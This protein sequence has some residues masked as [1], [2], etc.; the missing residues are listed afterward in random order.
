MIRFRPALLL[1]VAAT[2]T[3]ICMS[4]LA[5]WQRGGLTAERFVWI[6]TG[7]VL[8]A[9]AHLLPAICRSAPAVLRGVGT[10]LWLGCMA[11]TSYGHATFSFSRSRMPERCVS[12]RYWLVV[13]RRIVVLP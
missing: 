5:G 12:S 2:G 4:I 8:V 3:A 1:A 13:R 11:T 6:A 9:C 7:I 10:I